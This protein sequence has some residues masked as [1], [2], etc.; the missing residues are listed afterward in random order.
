[1]G[2]GVGKGAWCSKVCFTVDR[3][4]ERVKYVERFLYQMSE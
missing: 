4:G 2:G 3:A 1:M